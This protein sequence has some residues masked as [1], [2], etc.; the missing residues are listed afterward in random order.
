MICRLAV[1]IMLA[2]VVQAG[3]PWDDGFDGSLNPNWT[4]ST[5]G[6]GSSVS[7]V[8]GQMVFDTSITANSARSQVSTLTDSTGS[9]TTFNGGS[10]Y[11]FYDHPVSVRF[12]IASIAGTPNGPDGR[13]VFYFSIGDDSDGN[14]VP[15]GAIMDDGLGFRLEQL[16]TGGG[17]FWR[18]YYSE[19]VSGSATETLV[20]H[21][22]GL[23]SALVYRLNGTNASVQLEGTTVSFANWV[24]AGDTLAGSV[25]D[26]SSNI[27]TY[28]LAFGAY[29]LG[30]VSTPTE[31]RLDSLKVEPGFNVV[32]FG[33]IPD[34]GTDDTAGIQAALDAADALAGVDTVYLPTGDYLVDM[35]RIGG[36]T[37]FRGDGSQGSSVSQLMMNDYLPHGSNIL[38]NKNTVSGDPN[39]TIEKISFDGRKASQTNLFLHSVNMENVV[40]L[41][42]DDCEFHDS[43]AIGCAVQGD[44]SVDSHTVV[45]NSSSTGNELGFYAQSKNE[46]VNGLRGLVYSN[47]VANGDAWGFDVYLS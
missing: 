12:D 25:A 2:T 29:N 9:I 43:Q 18:L 15:V 6:A 21:L 38:R 26:L 7:Q 45:I 39:I 20:A 14:Y 44:L 10:L 42:V 40:G 11:N 24:S 33:A 41:L 31:V 5:A 36:D 30:A 46:V 37:I 34:D 17:A 32:S 3:V 4:T 19:L 23:P 1:L 8:G 13:N 35:L 28:T 47:C 27:S 16:D 22:N